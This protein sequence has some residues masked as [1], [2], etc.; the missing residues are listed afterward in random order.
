MG[1]WKIIWQ[2]VPISYETELG[3]L[4]GIT[5]KIIIPNNLNSEQIK[6][7]FHNLYGTEK[8][9]IEEVTVGKLK[10]GDEGISDIKTVT[11]KGNKRINL[12]VG[13]TFWSDVMI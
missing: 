12:E 4:E 9:E 7:K 6:I 3:I 5:Q 8:L 13:E 2:Y 10:S 1:D 11:Y